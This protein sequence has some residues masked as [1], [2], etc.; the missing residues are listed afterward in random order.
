MT[1]DKEKKIT[2]INNKLRVVEDKL[3]YDGQWWFVGRVQ[4]RIL[5]FWVDFEV[6]SNIGNFPQTKLFYSKKALREDIKDYK[7][8]Y[9]QNL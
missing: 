5:F 6:I 4:E 8:N 9:L 2:I 7:N 3:W 1:K